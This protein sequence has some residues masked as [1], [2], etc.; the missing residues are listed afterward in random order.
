[1]ENTLSSLFASV[2]W[3]QL[4]WLQPSEAEAWFEAR[5]ATR[6]KW[7]LMERLYKWL[8]EMVIYCSHFHVGQ[9]SQS[10][11]NDQLHIISLCQRWFRLMKWDNS[12]QVICRSTQQ[13]T[14]YSQIRSGCPVLFFQ[15]IRFERT[16]WKLPVC[17]YQNANCLH[18]VVST[19][20]SYSWI[21]SR[22]K[23]SVL[24]A[25]YVLEPERR[26]GKWGVEKQN[27]LIYFLY[28]LFFWCGLNY[29]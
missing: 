13:S 27:C 19:Q 23:L 25:V 8:S 29:L 21:L 15:C 14:K 4:P 1:M 2:Q 9:H 11:T 20:E 12:H 16:V 17:T 22:R 24:T 26:N 5:G 18:S 10:T 7:L 3:R 28:F 6:T